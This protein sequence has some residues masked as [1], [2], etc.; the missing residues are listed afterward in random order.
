M[1]SMDRMYRVIQK[2]VITEK[3]TDQ[4]RRNAFVFRVPLAVNKVEI[5]HAVEKLFDV[6]VI[7]VNTLRVPSKYRRRGYVAGHTSQW[8][9]AMVQLA[10]GN[11]IE[12]L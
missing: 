11:T 1:T 7:S 4:S 6:K 8:K 5:R 12:V 3:A 9:K 10:E 2:P